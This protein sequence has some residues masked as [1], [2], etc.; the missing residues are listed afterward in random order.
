MT[1]AMQTPAERPADQ[2]ELLRTYR[3]MLAGHDW[4]F[5]FSDDYSAYKRGALVLTQLNHL[6]AE[7]DPDGEIWNEYAKPEFK[8]K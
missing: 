3:K 5:A 2:A 8:I 1:Q 7:L 4:Y 6:R